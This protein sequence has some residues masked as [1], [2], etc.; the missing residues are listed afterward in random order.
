MSCVNLPAWVPGPFT[1][2]KEPVM[3]LDKR[4]ILLLAVTMS[5]AAGAALASRYRRQQVRAVGESQRKTDLKSWENEGGN[6]APIPAI[7]ASPVAAL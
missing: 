2:A 1:V 5:A 7:A 6:L 4:L 3:S